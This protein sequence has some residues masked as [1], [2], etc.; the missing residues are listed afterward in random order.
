MAL[1]EVYLFLKPT[2]EKT[3]FQPQLKSRWKTSIRSKPLHVHIIKIAVRTK[4]YLT[5]KRH[6]SFVLETGDVY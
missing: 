2:T 3:L 6:Y 4:C 1:P 5:V